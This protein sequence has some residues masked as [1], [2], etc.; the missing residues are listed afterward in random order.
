MDLLQAGVDTTVIA[1]WLGHESVETTQVYLNADLELKR[2][3]LAKTTPAG[4]A[5]PAFRPDDALLTF[6]KNL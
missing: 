6:L 2:K 3:V 5:P 1:M 4:S